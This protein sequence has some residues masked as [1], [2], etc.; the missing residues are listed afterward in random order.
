MLSGGVSKL[1][2]GV[3]NWCEQDSLTPNGKR[4]P[5]HEERRKQ[6]EVRRYGMA[7]F[8]HTYRSW[9]DDSGRR[10]GAAETDAARPDLDDDERV[11]KRLDDGQ[12]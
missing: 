4:L 11:R 8:P 2:A 3:G 6:R 7:Y 12:A 9:L 5:I 10:W 1:R